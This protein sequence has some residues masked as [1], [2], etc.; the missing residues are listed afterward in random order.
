MQN[1]WNESKLRAVIKTKLMLAKFANIYVG[2]THFACICYEVFT[3]NVCNIKFLLYQ[4][5]MHNKA[6]LFKK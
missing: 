2:T 1:E 5:L 6:Q 4:Y 3:Q